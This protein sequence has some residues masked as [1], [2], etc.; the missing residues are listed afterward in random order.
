MDF[1]QAIILGIVEGVT[2]FLPISSTGHLILTSTLLHLPSTEFVKSF[3]IFIQIGSILAIAVLFFQRYIQNFTIWKNVLASFIP[4]AIAG[5]IFYKLVKEVLLGNPMVTLVALFIGG[6]ALILVELMHK[7][8][9]S[10]SKEQDSHVGK[11]EDLTL[12]QSFLI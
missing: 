11:I 5:L 9:F 1:W 6:I 10:S 2:E 7:Q 3:E 8:S 12:K 4:T